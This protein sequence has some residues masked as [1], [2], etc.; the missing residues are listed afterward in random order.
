[1]PAIA[2]GDGGKCLTEVSIMVQMRTITK[3]W[4]TVAALAAIVVWG[5]APAAAGESEY[6]RRLQDRYTFLSTQQLLAE[7]H[8]VCNA[9]D[10][11]ALSSSSVDMVSKDLGVSLAVAGDIV[12]AAAVELG[13]GPA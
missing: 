5:A 10:R 11:G 12:A 13:C 2:I 8:K 7:G 4:T 3:A 9:L 1:L 6:L